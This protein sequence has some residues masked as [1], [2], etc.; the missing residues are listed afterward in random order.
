MTKLRYA[1][2]LMT[3]AT[4]LIA[5]SAAMP[6]FAPAYAK[7][8]LAVTIYNSGTA[9][10]EDKRDI[11]FR[12]GRSKVE[13]P[14]VSSQII[15]PS[16]T[17]VADGIE[18]I[19]QN[20]DFDLLSP[21]KLMEKAVG[22][23]VEIVRINPGTGRETRQRAKVLS[24]NNGV[25]I[26]AGGKIEVLRDDNLPTRVIFDGVPKNLRARPTLS[27]DVTSAK[28]G[29]REA[30]LTYLTG[31]LGW[32]SDYVL[33][34]DEADS[35]MDLQGWA[36]LTNRTETTFEQA[37]LVLVAGNVQSGG[38]GGDRPRSSSRRGGSENTAPERIGDNYLY[39]IPG[40]TT[41]ASNQTKQV[42]LVDVAGASATKVYEYQAGGFNSMGNP[43][44]VDVRI[45]FANSR[46]TGLGTA[47]PGGT[48]RVYAKDA[49]GRAQFI[50]EDRLGHTP[51]GS[52][53]SLK[54]GSAFDV[55]VQ[56]TVTNKKTINKRTH[57]TTMKYVV[58]NAK[59]D[60]ATV[61]VRQRV[62]GWWGVEH[63]MMNESLKSRRPQ[64]DMFVWEVP[65]P[66]EGETTLTFTVRTKSTW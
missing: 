12:D 52:D 14:G 58:R 32:S 54:I 65:V 51:G 7:D 21:A 56:S 61:L 27:V 38:R 47:L 17:F 30:A 66:A 25:V 24:V 9:L 63:T 31:G 44:N 8:D 15:A 40:R 55:T 57:E 19:E 18:I 53:I 16:V 50:G 23:T 48:V 33:L 4:A 35:Q 41:I 29:K 34:F 28:S 6:V 64:N 10:V 43:Q 39:P 49:R 26:E 5:L 36:T 37:N 13:L 62:G 20:F 11:N 46:K 59:P 22:Q 2:F 60:A 45:A 3:T 1:K 42:S